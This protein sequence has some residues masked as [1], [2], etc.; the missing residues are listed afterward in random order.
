[1]ISVVIPVFNSET[2]LEACVKSVISQ[3][4]PHFIEIVIIDDGSTDNSVAIAKSLIPTLPNNRA[5]NIFSKENGGVSS[6]R[7][8]GIRHS[9]QEWI[10]LLDSDD[11]WVSEKLELQL[12]E[13]L[14]NS[15]I[16]FLGTNFNDSCYFG[17]KDKGPKIFSLSPF[18]V[19]LKWWPYTS[20]MLIK[21]SALEK[22]N[23]AFDESMR[24]G[25]DGR[26]LLLLSRN[27][28]IYV[29]NISTVYAGNGKRTFGE[30]GL[31]KDLDKMYSG[32]IQNLFFAKKNLSINLPQFIFLYAWLRFKYL[33]RIF[34]VKA[35]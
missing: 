29:L 21:R 9:S 33:R 27:Y 7:N 26:F 20:T 4:T 35:A 22:Y 28:K 11:Q 34:I 1:M 23:I 15:S 3:T 2:T 19:L 32:E 10:A 16:D 12:N 13:V 14:I 24:R 5:I 6:A 30:A 25:E 8:L 17:M 18:Q 31:S